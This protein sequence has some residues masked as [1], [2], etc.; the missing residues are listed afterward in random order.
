LIAVGCYVHRPSIARKNFG[1]FVR[2]ERVLGFKIWQWM[3][4]IL[5]VAVVMGVLFG[6]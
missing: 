3:V 5:M 6:R 1:A 4:A 2:G